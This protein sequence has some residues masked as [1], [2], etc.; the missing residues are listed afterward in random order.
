MPLLSRRFALFDVSDVEA[1]C[2]KVLDSSNVPL[3][4]YEDTL[5]E[6][7]ADCWVLSETYDPARTPSFSTFAYRRL[8]LRVVDAAR[9]RYRTRWVFRDS[10]YER[11]AP[12]LLNFDVDDPERGRLD[13]TLASRAGDPADDRD[14]SLAGL[15]EGGDSQR[16][17]D[18]DELG[19]EPPGRAA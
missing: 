16:A 11:P 4:E 8:R 1:L 13:D 14:S 9:R 19:L 7:I 2:R 10:V 6:L 18:L 3:C 17:R 5:V 12:Q 15:L